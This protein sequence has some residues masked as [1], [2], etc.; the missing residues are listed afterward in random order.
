MR[1]PLLLP[2]LAAAALI[3]LPSS[4]AAHHAGD[5]DCSD[6]PDKAAAQAHLA[7][8][9]GDPDG[10]DRQRRRRAV[11]VAAVPVCR[12]VGACRIRRPRSP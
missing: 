1:R 10:L 7:A 3:G 12:L 6:F 5:L 8:H 11:R 2:I 4:A 9:P